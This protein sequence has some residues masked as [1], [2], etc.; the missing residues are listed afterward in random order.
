MCENVASDSRLVSLLMSDDGEGF[1]AVGNWIYHGKMI[2]S[3]GVFTFVC[4][5]V[6]MGTPPIK[7]IKAATRETLVEMVQSHFQKILQ[8]LADGK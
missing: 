7:T 2:T 6:S 8:T 4:F 3:H 5:R 1:F